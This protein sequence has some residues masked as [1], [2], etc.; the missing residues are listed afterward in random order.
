MGQRAT[1][2]S[3][4]RIRCQAASIGWGVRF[5]F[6]KRRPTRSRNATNSHGL[7]IAPAVS[8]NREAEKQGRSAVS[9]GLI[10]DAS[11][12]DIEGPQFMSR[13]AGMVL[14]RR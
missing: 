14:P 11:V 9:D 13:R 4:W 7:R 12:S 1:E 8:G 3:I 6:D 10:S 5:N 2:V